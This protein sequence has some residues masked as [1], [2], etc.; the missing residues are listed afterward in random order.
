MKGLF[1]MEKI[2]DIFAGEQ[3]SAV[4]TKKGKL[5]I[6]GSVL[7]SKLDIIPEEY[8]G[9]IVDMKGSSYNMLLLLDN[10]T[11]GTLGVAGN[12][13]SAVPEELKDGSVKAEQIAISLSNGLVL[14]DQG[15]LTA[16]NEQG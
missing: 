16:M 2:Q 13:F 14:D 10:G 8:Q 12:D 1:E 4:L 7:S 9:H 6:W 11:V 15:N 3:Y 5:Y